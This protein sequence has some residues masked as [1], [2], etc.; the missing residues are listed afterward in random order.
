MSEHSIAFG[1]LYEAC[2]TEQTSEQK[3]LPPRYTGGDILLVHTL[4]LEPDCR[5]YGIGLLALDKLMKRTARASPA[6]GKNG[7][8]VL[9]PSGLRECLEP[10]MSNHGQVQEK[11]IRNYQLLGLKVLVRGSELSEHA[12][13]VGTWMGGERPDIATVVPHLFTPSTRSDAPKTQSRSEKE[14]G[15]ITMR[16]IPELVERRARAYIQ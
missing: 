12:T 9:D 4:Y 10:D 15:K 6:W 3:I 11:L 7:L 1:M 13:F 14:L 2:F 8:T 16:D 5:G